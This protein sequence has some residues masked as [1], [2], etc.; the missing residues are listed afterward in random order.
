VLLEGFV[1]IAPGDISPTEIIRS[2]RPFKL[3]SIVIISPALLGP[4][5]T[6]IIAFERIVPFLALILP[7]ARLSK[8]SG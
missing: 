1:P 5:G 7:P 2:D 8:S 3:D 6:A 4:R